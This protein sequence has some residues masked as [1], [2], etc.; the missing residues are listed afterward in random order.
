M[1]NPISRLQAIPHKLSRYR[2]ILGVLAR[3]GFAEW[4]ERIPLG[5]AKEV[6]S[7]GMDPEIMEDS[8]EGRMRRALEE[9]GPTFI[10]LG[11]LLSTRPDVVGPG[12]SQALQALQDRAPQDPPEAVKEVLRDSFDQRLDELFAEFQPAP[13]ASAS[14]AQVHRAVMQSGE[15]VVLKIQ[16]LEVEN[17]VET[18]LDILLDLAELLERY[19]PESRVYRPTAL[20]EEFR[21]GLLRELDFQRELHHM[22]AFRRHFQDDRTL[23]IPKPYP[24]LSNRR[25]L[26][27]ERVQGVKA[28]DPDALRAQGTDPTHIASEG[29][30]IFLD[31]IFEHGLFHGDPH[32]G[33]LLVVGGDKIALLDFGLVGRLDEDLRHDLEDIFIGIAQRDAHRIA[34]TFSKMGAVSADLDRDQFQRD[35]YELLDYYADMSLGDIDAA[36]AITELIA[37]IRRHRIVLPPD[38]ALLAKVIMTL[39]GT[40]RRL[41]PSFQL[42]RLVLPYQ[43]KIVRQRFSPGRQFRKLQRITEDMNTMLETLPSSLTDVVRQMREGKFSLQLELREMDTARKEQQRS[44][45]RLTFGILTASL[46]LAASG[47]LAARVPPLLLGDYS[48]PG[49]AGLSISLVFGTRLLW[50]IWRSH[51]LN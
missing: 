33:N 47:L 34:R 6:L 15:E 7:R 38:L 31:M 37:V 1:E 36:A 3:Y 35:L 48:I 30:R 50:A 39:D 8:T 13:L 26:A 21:K 25:V 5:F 27:M 40:G 29:A 22:E 14:I 12:V 43:Q 45:N 11:Q 4:F 10:K 24:E 42:M 23:R 17:T 49:L 32:P 51:D 19:V 16:H 41:D 18:D 20:V 2:H 28:V 44:T 46:F 9:L